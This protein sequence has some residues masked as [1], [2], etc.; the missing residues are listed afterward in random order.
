MELEAQVEP[1]SVSAIRV[2][3]VDEEVVIRAG[4]R[5]LI[6]GW[7]DSQVVGE[8]DSPNQALAAMDAFEPNLIVCSHPGRSNGFFDGFRNLLE[9]AGQ[10]PVILLT[11]SRDPQARIRAVQAG[12]KWIFLKKHAATELRNALE[13][14]H[15]GLKWTDRFAVTN[16]VTPMNGSSR[17]GSKRWSDPEQPFTKR[18]REV[19]VLVS[20]GRTNRQVASHLG[21][22][23]VTVRHHLTSIFSKLRIGNRFELIAWLYRNGVV[24]P[25]V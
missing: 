16:R 22:T 2:L 24:N 4:L 23:E 15:S 18:E 25:A 11:G 7:P 1:A 6:N 9:A 8:A 3:L 19:A 14:V 20:Q 21:I 10:T 17:D 5:I 13:R 12:A